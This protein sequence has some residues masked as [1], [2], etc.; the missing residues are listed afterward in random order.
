MVG[1]SSLCHPD[2]NHHYISV[3][4]IQVIALEMHVDHNHH[5]IY[6]MAKTVCDNDFF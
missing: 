5:V 1:E 2:I 4:S 3:L 6:A